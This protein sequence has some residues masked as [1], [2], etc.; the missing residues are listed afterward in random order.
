MRISIRSYKFYKYLFKLA[1]C[2][3]RKDS[4]V[5]VISPT[6]IA[7]ISSKK[8]R[9]TSPADVL[10]LIL[11]HLMGKFDSILAKVMSSHS[12]IENIWMKEE[13]LKHNIF[14][15]DKD[16][17]TGTQGKNEI[18]IWSKIVKRITRK[19]HGI[20]YF[21]YDSPSMIAE[22]VPVSYMGADEAFFI[23]ENNK[24]QLLKKDI[25]E[26]KDFETVFQHC[27]VFFIPLV[28]GFWF[29]TLYVFLC[30]NH[31]RPNETQLQS[32]LGEYDYHENCI[33][34]CDYKKITDFLNAYDKC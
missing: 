6:Q 21:V 20:Y 11:L 32:V 17:K 27:K 15:A 7:T 16:L 30:N 5:F 18:G 19:S 29:E 24:L 34:N 8:H 14:V 9:K 31:Y 4:F 23:V 1:K 28:P 33:C 26:N 2:S 22:Y 12:T 13:R 10:P 25:T 3:K